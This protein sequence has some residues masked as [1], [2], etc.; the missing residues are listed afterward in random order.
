MQ[1]VLSAAEGLLLRA[2]FNLNTA[3]AKRYNKATDREEENR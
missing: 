2:I 1:R 3:G